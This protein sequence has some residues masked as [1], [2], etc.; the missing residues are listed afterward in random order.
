MLLLDSS[1][2]RTRIWQDSIACARELPSDPLR[3]QYIFI[4]P[5]CVPGLV[6][7]PLLSPCLRPFNSTQLYADAINIPSSH[8]RRGKCDV[9]IFVFFC[10]V[11]SSKG[12][13]PFFPSPP[14][15]LFDRYLGYSQL[16]Q[17]RSDRYPMRSIF[18]N[19]LFLTMIPLY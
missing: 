4:H 17:G 1:R 19:R 9:G 18:E 5:I 13:R 16:D 14:T 6:C 10:S 15:L 12:R 11:D 8:R 2:V 3:T 7:P